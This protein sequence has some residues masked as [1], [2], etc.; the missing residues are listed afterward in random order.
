[1]K[2]TMKKFLLLIL[3]VLMTAFVG[4]FAASCGGEELG[5]LKSSKILYDGNNITWSRVSGAKEYIVIVNGAAAKTVDQPAKGENPK[6]K[7]PS[8]GRNEVD[9]SIQ[10]IGKEEEGKKASRTFTRLTTIQTSDITFSEE[11]VMSWNIVEGADSYMLKLGD[12]EVSVSEEEYSEFVYDGKST[13]IQIKP[14]TTDGSTFSDYSSS[15]SKVFLAE[16]DP[17]KVN[18]DGEYLTWQGQG[19]AQGYEIYID[20]A[21]KE[22]VGRNQTEFKFPDPAQN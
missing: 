10:P 16:V 14:I 8:K 15:I 12:T 13:S 3:T 4:V 19:Y 9:V 5:T 2:K 17:A 20:G 1:M 22:T 11:G 6:F 7:Y 21:F 18:Y